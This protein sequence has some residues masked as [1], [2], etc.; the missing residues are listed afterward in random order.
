MKE[1]ILNYSPALIIEIHGSNYKQ[2]A[3]NAKDVVEILI[4]S[5]YSIYHIESNKKITLSNI[6]I[7]K[8]GHLYAFK[9][10]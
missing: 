5:D 3:K 4:S 10:N 1:T 2:K 6:A 7:A 8:K 9:K